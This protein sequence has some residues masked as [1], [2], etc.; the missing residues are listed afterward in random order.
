MGPAVFKLLP[1]PLMLPLTKRWLGPVCCS[2]GFAL[3]LF[4]LSVVV[5][6]DRTVRKRRHSRCIFT[7]T[8]I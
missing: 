2:G 4:N 5:S 3:L 1:G 6:Q 7:I 8:L